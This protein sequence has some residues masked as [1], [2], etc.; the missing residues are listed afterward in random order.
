MNPNPEILVTLSDELLD[1]IRRQARELHVPMK[2]LVAGL[3]CDTIAPRDES[4][5]DGSPHP[6]LHVA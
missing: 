2:W 3:V 5:E 6:T 1:R 4:P